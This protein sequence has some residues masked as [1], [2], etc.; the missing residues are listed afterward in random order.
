MDR[1]GKEKDEEEQEE[2]EAAVMEMQ[3]KQWQVL[4]DSR[5]KEGRVGDEYD[6]ERE[7]ERE[8]AEVWVLA[9]PC[10]L[11]FASVVVRRCLFV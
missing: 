3:R 2:A 9:L 4:G 11:S 10:W 8:R 7:R 6:R 5:E 1:H